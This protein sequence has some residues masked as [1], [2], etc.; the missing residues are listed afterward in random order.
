VPTDK[1]QYIRVKTLF[2]AVLGM[3]WSAATVSVGAPSAEAYS[4][5]AVKAAFVMRFASYIEW[6]AESTPATRFEIAVLGASDVAVRM[7]RLVANRALVGQTVQVRRITRVQDIG[8]ARILYVGTDRREDLRSLLAP[9][10]GRSILVISAEEDALA[11]GSTINLLAA[12]N[13]VRFE[14]S[15]VAARRAKLKISSDLLALAVRVQQ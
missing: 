11:S 1:R 7:Q 2:L 6:P 15:L 4:D 9:L 13:R 10:Q 12:D 8:D 3:L 14:V 5:E